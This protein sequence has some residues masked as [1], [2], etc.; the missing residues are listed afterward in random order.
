MPYGPSHNIARPARSRWLALLL[1]SSRGQAF[2]ETAIGVLL[3]L[4]MSWAVVDAG[5]L[6]WTYLTLENAVTEAARYASTHQTIT[7]LSR[8]DSIKSQLRALAPGITIPDG[9]IS[10]Y[11]ITTNTNDAGGFNDLIR[12]SVDHVHSPVLPLPMFLNSAHRNFRIRVSSI[13][14]NEPQG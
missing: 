1:R 11:D 7:G 3:I 12:V 9:E 14:R 10:F 5:A 4:G 2:V 13:V 6:F 8:S